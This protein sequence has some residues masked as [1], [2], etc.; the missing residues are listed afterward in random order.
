MAFDYQD[1]INASASAIIEFGA[2]YKLT[3]PNNSSAGSVHA[4]M[5]NQEKADEQGV[6][7]HQKVMLIAGNN[8][9]IPEIGMF[10]TSGKEVYRIQSLEIVKPGRFTIIYKAELDV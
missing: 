10:M 1:V 5:T 4:V 7:T 9:V 2:L 8:R 3:K 6:I